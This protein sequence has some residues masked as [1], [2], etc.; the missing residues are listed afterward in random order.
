MQE[1]YHRELVERLL[2]HPHVL[3]KLQRAL[4]V[5]ALSSAKKV[6][7]VDY[8]WGSN[9]EQQLLQ[10]VMA[11]LEPAAQA[12]FSEGIEDGVSLY[13]LGDVSESTVKRC[14][15]TELA[16]LENMQD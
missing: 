14:A 10:S 9:P 11:D 6:L 1:S 15:L 8:G 2:A 4:A 5:D 7:E 3:E 12:Y 13:D 16:P